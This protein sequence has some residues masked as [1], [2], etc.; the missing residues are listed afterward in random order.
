MLRH[1]RN[2]LSGNCGSGGVG[3]ECILMR[4]TSR[5]PPRPRYISIQSELKP[6]RPLTTRLNDPSRVVGIGRARIE[7]V[8][9]V[10]CTRQK[11]ILMNIP[12]QSKFIV[13]ELLWFDLLRDC[14]Q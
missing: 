4:V 12:L 11:Q 7:S 8:L 10:E 13:I 2:F 3:Y 6:I 14:G 5:D 9:P 1:L